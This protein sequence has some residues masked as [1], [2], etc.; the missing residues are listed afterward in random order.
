MSENAAVVITLIT[1]PRWSGLESGRRRGESR[2]DDG[3]TPSFRLHRLHCA[4]LDMGV[5]RN[6]GTSKVIPLAAR[7]RL[8]K[9]VVRRLAGIGASAAS[10]LPLMRRCALA[11]RRRRA[12]IGWARSQPAHC[13]PH[14]F[15]RPHR[16]ANVSPWLAW[17]RAQFSNTLL[18]PKPWSPSGSILCPPPSTPA[19]LLPITTPPTLVSSPIHIAASQ[20]GISTNP[21]PAPIHL[22]TDFAMF[23]LIALA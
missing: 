12:A 15:A 13:M 4:P 7:A 23:A 1:A 6:S 14:G 18:P 22:C 2:G 10:G 17:P 16:A 20:S 9:P 5:T 11:V 19:T 8:R 3:I 21:I